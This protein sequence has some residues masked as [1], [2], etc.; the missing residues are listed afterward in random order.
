MGIDPETILATSHGRRSIDVFELLDP[1]KANWECKFGE[2]FAP[3]AEKSAHL[4][5]D[6]SEQERL[7]P[8]EFGEDAEEI[9]GARKLLASL[10]A[11]DAP[12]AIVTSGTGALINGWIR[13]LRLAQPKTMVVAEEVSK[14]K[15]DP[16]PYLVG[17]QRLGLDK[18]TDC[19]VFEDA[20]SGIRAGKAA[21]FRVIALATTHTIAQLKE[22]GADW[23]LRDL[24]SV[25]ID[26][27][28]DGLVQIDISDAL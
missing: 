1:S 24:R 6:V 20:P 21:G 9:P 11:L 13:V 16:E 23:I 19:V 22:A 12:W 18:G 8:I 28:Q 15:P 26:Y 7:I 10:D 2:N 25:T 3:Y 27:V 4:T 5:L 14:G 17:R